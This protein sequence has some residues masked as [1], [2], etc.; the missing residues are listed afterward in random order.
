[1]SISSLRASAAGAAREAQSR[2]SDGSPRP[3]KAYLGLMATYLGLVGA[4][5]AAVRQRRAP[6]PTRLSAAD[7]ALVAVATH[8]AARMVTKETVTSP[9][10]APFTTFRGAAGD[11]ELH[12]D[13]TAA[14]AKHA[15]GELLTCPFCAGH[16]IATVFVF[17]LVL[18]PRATRLVCGIL[19][20]VAGSDALQLGYAVAQHLEHRAAP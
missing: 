3:L 6:L 16:W 13:V 7:L 2:Y 10:R 8:K 20:A 17:G 1:M 14:G 9:L 19:A 12:E 11:A 4:L 5:S 15:V 18:A